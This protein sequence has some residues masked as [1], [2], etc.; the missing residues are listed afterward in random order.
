MSIRTRFERALSLVALTVARGALAQDAAAQDAPQASQEATADDPAIAA[1]RERFKMGLERYKAGDVAQAIQ[2]WEPLYRDLGQ[3]KGYRV[4]YDLAR[5]YE[6]FGDA[7]RAAERFVAFVDETNMRRSSG[8]AIDELV[9]KEALDATERLESLK[10]NRARISV[11]ATT[12]P[13]SVAVDA[14]EPRLAGFVAYVVAGAHTVVF[15]PGSDD[16]QKRDV[17]VANGEEVQVTMDTPA[18][19]PPLPPPPSANRLETTHPFTSAWIVF[20]GGATLASSVLPYLA[21]S[22]SNDLRA[23]YSPP[24]AAT[25]SEQSD[26]SLSR[27]LAY[28]S[29]A[30]PIALGLF[31][32]A[33]AT[34][35]FAKT[36][37]VWVPV[38]TEKQAGF[39]IVGAF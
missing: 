11:P 3:Q 28:A 30:A 36:K 22:H 8:V 24:H 23:R 35:Y 16:M 10:R 17:T 5:A 1:Y 26:Y 20:A 39:S 33:L 7:T 13:S 6:T 38:L 32:A 37:T 27:S 21:Y 19:P 29:W 2:Y 25:T 4:A 34:V 12:P 15:D 9:A 14:T 18:A 31:T